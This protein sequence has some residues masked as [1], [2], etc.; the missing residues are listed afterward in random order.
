MTIET[1]QADIGSP[2]R[3][4]LLLGSAPDSRDVWF[5]DDP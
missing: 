3:S 1:S 5:P 4:P 2:R